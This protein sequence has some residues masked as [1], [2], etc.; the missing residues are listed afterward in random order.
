M[1]TEMEGGRRLGGCEGCRDKADGVAAKVNNRATA[2]RR[3]GKFAKVLDAVIV[4][5]Q[6]LPTLAGAI[7][8]HTLVDRL[9]AMKEDY[10]NDDTK[11]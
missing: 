7:Q 5:I 2:G 6:K 10:P 3:R 8:K 11:L 4:E 9:R 1:R